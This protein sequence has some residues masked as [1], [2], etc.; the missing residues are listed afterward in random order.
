MPL[1]TGVI[2]P[3]PDSV[4]R[5][6]LLCCS[7]RKGLTELFTKTYSTKV[8][9]EKHTDMAPPPAS[10]VT[11]PFGEGMSL[12][13]MRAVKGPLPISLNT[14]TPKV[15]TKLLVKVAIPGLEL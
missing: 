11:V 2:T 4:M 6:V 9:L 7:N 12:F 5:P 13:W 10:V 3:D 15:P 8:L 14:S 1:G